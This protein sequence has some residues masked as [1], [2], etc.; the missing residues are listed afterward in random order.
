MVNRLEETAEVNCLLLNFSYMRGG[1][2]T[3][4]FLPQMGLISMATVLDEAGISTGVIDTLYPKSSQLIDFIEKTGVKVVGFYCNFDNRFRIGHFI[5]LCR[6]R[7]NDVVYLVGG[8]QATA[9]PEETLRATGCDFLFMGE[10]EPQIVPLVRSILE[11][12][13]DHYKS[14]GVCYLKDDRLIKTGDPVL[15]NDL[16]TIPFLNHRLV[17]YSEAQSTCQ[18]IITGRGCPYNCTFCFESLSGKSYRVRSIPHVISEIEGLLKQGSNYLGIVDDTFVAFPKR[19]YDFCDALK[20]LRKEYDFFW[21]CEGRADIFSRHPDLLPHMVQAGLARAQIGAETGNNH[22]LELYKKQI[23]VDQVRNTVRQAVEHDLL[24]L[25]M[26]F[27]VGG[28]AETPETIQ[29][30]IDFACELITLAPGRVDISCN[31][32]IPYPQTEIGRHPEKFGLRIL[33]PEV[34]SC[35]NEEYPVVE[36]EAMDR[37]AIFQAYRRFDLALYQTMLRQ[38]T[39]IPFPLLRRHFEATR[40]SLLTSWCELFQDI[41]YVSNYFTLY[42]SQPMT[43]LA[44]LANCREALD[45]IPLRTQQVYSLEKGCIKLPLGDRTSLLNRWGTV[46][47]E[48]AA[49]K[50]NIREIAREAGKR[51]GGCTPPEDVFIDHIFDFYRSLEQAYHII[52]SPI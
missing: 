14:P 23:T 47:Y 31:F 26:N 4:A 5:R 32:L 28:P 45:L 39:S 7:L 10:G 20:P 19:V 36:T 51:F 38:L 50:L 43:R 22:I 49:G 21:F 1:R 9:C 52:F 18:N 34:F 48:L 11:G 6:S 16:D 41:P 12:R 30:S 29:K 40:Y 3:P 15:I 2:R 33:D 44:D 8:P 24:S 46:L 37:E 35:F 27:I 13:K 17:L 25:F 42:L